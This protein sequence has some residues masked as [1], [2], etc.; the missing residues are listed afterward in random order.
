MMRLVFYR[1]LS[2][3]IAASHSAIYEIGTV[4]GPHVFHK[5]GQAGYAAE[6]S[7]AI[8]QE[9]HGP[10][11]VCCGVA[12]SR[13]FRSHMGQAGLAAEWPSRDSSGAT[14]AKSGNPNRIINIGTGPMPI[15]S[16]KKFNC[17]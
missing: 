12:K 2:D 3:S 8:L 16:N 1:I 9:P 14:W 6:W 7:A 11:R 17:D 13:F 10:S 5:M 15:N 4:P